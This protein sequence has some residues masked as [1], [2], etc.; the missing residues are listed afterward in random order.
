MRSKPKVS[1]KLVVKVVGTNE[2]VK[3]K[4][5]QFRIRAKRLFLTYSQCKL[6]PYVVFEKLRN[7]FPKNTIVNYAVVIEDHVDE[8]GVHLHCYLEFSKKVD[9]RKADFLD[10]DEFHGNYQG[11][12]NKKA[13]LEYVLKI[14]VNASSVVSREILHRIKD[15]KYLNEARYLIEL[16]K[17]GKISEALDQ[18]QVRDPKKY[19]NVGPLKLV[20]KLTEIYEYHQPKKKRFVNLSEFD[21]TK[22]P[23]GVLL[24]FVKYLKN[25]PFLKGQTVY[26]SGRT[27]VGKT[28]LIT[29]LCETLNIKVL[30]ITHREDLKLLRNNR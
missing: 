17:S 30:R 24:L 21:Y 20:Q 10:V 12:K 27:A 7:K 6:E 16:A 3:R 19:L 23:I 5:K 2:V 22:V 29:R 18:I 25:E 26:W 9:I 1:S 14:G 4:A 28:A 8:K 11:V 15:G 13:A